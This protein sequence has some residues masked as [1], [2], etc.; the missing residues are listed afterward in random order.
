MQVLVA[1]TLHSIGLA[2]L[3][4]VIL[5][6]M[7][8]IHGTMISNGVGCIP[9]FVRLFVKSSITRTTFSNQP[10][11]TTDENNNIMDSEDDDE[12]EWDRRNK[13][14]DSFHYYLATNRYF[15]WINFIL[16]II[17]IVGWTLFGYFNEFPQFYLMPIAMIL[18]IVSLELI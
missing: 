4:F 16:Q 5:P 1:E 6:K 13:S 11:Q 3:V 7:N 18:G 2:L 12:E 14:R 10:F 15:A 9:I 17:I 8:V